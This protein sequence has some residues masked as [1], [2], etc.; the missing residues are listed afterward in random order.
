MDGA[1]ANL[2][3]SAGVTN[4]AGEFQYCYIGANLGVDN[5][6]A[7][8]GAVNGP[9]SATS[10]ITVTDCNIALSDVIS[11]LLCNGDNSGAI[12]LTVSGTYGT[13]Q[14]LSFSWTGPNGFAANTE[15]VSGLKAGSYTVVVSSAL[16]C[17]ETGNYMVE[18][19]NPIAVNYSAT[20]ILCNGGLSQESVIV[21][22]GTAP[23]DVLNQDNGALALGLGEGVLA[24]G[25]TFAAN[26]VY[27][28]ADANGCTFVFN[29]NIPE[30][31]ALT[32]QID[33]PSAIP[34]GLVATVYPGWSPDIELTA[35]AGGGTSGYT[36]SWSDGQTSDVVTVSPAATTVYTVTITDANNCTTTCSVTINVIDATCGK[37][38]EKVL[39]CHNGNTICISPNAVP[40]HFANHAG[41]YLGPCANKTNITGSTAF[42]AYPNPS[43]G[44]VNLEIEILDDAE[45]QIEVFSA[46]G[47]IVYAENISEKA[48]H[49]VHSINLSNVSS[50]VYMI[51]LMNNGVV[52]MQRVQ[53]QK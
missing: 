32:C 18:E 46:T 42:R 50:G 31:P 16:G 33:L 21:T 52:E 43:A 35:V 14:D 2:G 5:I 10:I 51:K 47:Q 9:K 19:P 24:N 37:K 40:A 26:Y 29:A 1:G 27:T 53:I 34:G 3:G 15:D 4:A 28:V 13:P 23:Y 48:G 36:Y 30:P 25:Q 17:S 7:W 44:V 12:D 49:Y 11:D 22:G 38:N 39:V 6:T 41:D 20:P 45:L 8:L